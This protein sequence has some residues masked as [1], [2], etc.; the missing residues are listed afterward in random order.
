MEQTEQTH[1]LWTSKTWFWFHF[2]IS[3]NSFQ[4]L[5]N[6]SKPMYTLWS[7]KTWFLFHLRTYFLN[8][9]F[10][11]SPKLFQYFQIFSNTSE[12]KLPI[13]PAVHSRRVHLARV[14]GES[15][16]RRDGVSATLYT[17]A[18]SSQSARGESKARAYRRERE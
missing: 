10:K 9:C 1:T 17:L 4:Y 5:Q 16:P 15:C 18:E 8:N 14:S 6:F 7:S 2:K 12:F 11:I 3:S 13:M